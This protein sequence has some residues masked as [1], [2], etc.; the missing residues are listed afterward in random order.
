[1]EQRNNHLDEVIKILNEVL[2]NLPKPKNDLNAA[3]YQSARKAMGEYAFNL[4]QYAH[5]FTR[6][7]VNKIKLSELCTLLNTLKSNRYFKIQPEQEQKIRE[8]E[9]YQELLQALDKKI[10]ELT[11][12]KDINSLIQQLEN[13]GESIIDDSII[14]R[15]YEIIDK[16][17]IPKETSIKIFKELMKHINMVSQKQIVNTPH[18]LPNLT[19]EQLTEL[20]NKYGYDF[21]KVPS[22]F[23][24][25][26]LLN[27]NLN[28]IEELFQC[29]PSYGIKFIETNKN[30]LYLLM[31]SSKEILEKMKELS[32]K[33]GF[34]FTNTLE[35]MPAAFIH[36]TSPQEIKRIKKEQ[37]N[38]DDISVHGAFED[39]CSN[40]ELIEKLGYNISV[41]MQKTQSLFVQPYKRTITNVEILKEYGIIKNDNLALAGFTLS[42]LKSTNLQEII[43]L[44]I[45]LGE[46]QYVK[47][48]ASRLKLPKDSY[49]FKRLYFGKINGIPNLTKVWG[50]KV[51][52]TGIISDENNKTLDKYINEESIKHVVFDEQLDGEIE[53]L[54]EQ[55]LRKLDY[56]S[57]NSAFEQIEELEKEYKK[58][59]N[60]YNFNGTIISIRKVRKIYPILLAEYPQLDRKKLLLFA[61]TYNSMM[62]HEEFENIKKLIVA[63]E[64]RK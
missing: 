62:S 16:Y 38:D 35:K 23:Q 21:G 43:D 32:Q 6:T 2:Q 7:E 48:N 47:D 42:G 37:Q 27:G 24:K 40:I 57:D 34:S 10:D 17:E 3:I 25:R 53:A 30:S 15:L 31:K 49:I 14:D 33:Y 61:V 46:L 64:L 13:I 4:T 11:P 5:L 55:T 26:I 63:K 36:K 28:N 22:D 8:H 56:K 58:D 50:P 39:F 41:A 60:I 59:D 44:F 12:G 18:V 19:E 1:M 9:D 45:E 29:M 54:L 20:F 52:L 51:I